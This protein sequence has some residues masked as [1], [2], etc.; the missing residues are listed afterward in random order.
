MGQNDHVAARPIT[1]ANRS[2]ERGGAQRT[3]RLVNESESKHLAAVARSLE[4]ADE[5]AERGNYRDALGW[6]QAVE[7][8]GDEL[9]ETYEA[10]RNAWLLTISAQRSGS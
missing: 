10:K 1:N 6:L 4:W 2:S 3:S 7:A 5:A 8:A 9:P